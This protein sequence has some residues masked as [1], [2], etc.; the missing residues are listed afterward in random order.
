MVEVFNSTAQGSAYSALT[1]E[2]I[3]TF[4]IA[5][6]ELAVQKNIVEKLNNVFAEIVF[7][8]EKTNIAREF[9]AAFRQS[10]LSSAFTLE[11]DE[12]AT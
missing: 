11:T 7:L 4:R 1:I 10:L 12:E 8:K 2:K 5:V 3:K 9:I 6:P